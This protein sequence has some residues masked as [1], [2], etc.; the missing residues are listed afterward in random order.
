MA[1]KEIVVSAPL[2]IFLYDRT[3]VRARFARLRRRT[4]LYLALRRLVAAVT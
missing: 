2:V 1:T 3:F 4:R